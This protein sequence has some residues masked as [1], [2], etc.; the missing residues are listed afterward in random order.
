MAKV[1]ILKHKIDLLELEHKHKLEILQIQHEAELDA[2]KSQCTHTYEDGSSSYEFFGTQRDSVDR[3][4]I[5]GR[6]R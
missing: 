3:C 2:L 1:S 6:I 4:S 5:C